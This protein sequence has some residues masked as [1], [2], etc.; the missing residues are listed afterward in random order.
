M[1]NPAYHH[2]GMNGYQNPVI[3][4]HGKYMEPRPLVN[5]APYLQRFVAG[6]QRL[7]QNP[8]GEPMRN[9]KNGNSPGRQPN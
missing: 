8:L 6:P 7:E 5:N 1:H 2:G 9:L 3:D 4:T